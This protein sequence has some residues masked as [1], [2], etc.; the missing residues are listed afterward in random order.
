MVSAPQPGICPL[1][2]LILG[3]LWARQGAFTGY[4][5]QHLI[6]NFPPL[7]DLTIFLFFLSHF[8]IQILET[9]CNTFIKLVSFY[10]KFVI[11]NLTL[12]L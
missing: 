1:R 4:D 2:G 12:T 10:N 9:Y 6:P 8:S 7:L 5:L 3:H 11:Q